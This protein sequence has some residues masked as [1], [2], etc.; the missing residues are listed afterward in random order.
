MELRHGVDLMLR[1]M[2]GWTSNSDCPNI[3]AFSGGSAASGFAGAL[4]Q[5][6]MYT[7][8]WRYHHRRDVVDNRL[9]ITVTLAPWVERFADD[10][11]RAGGHVVADRQ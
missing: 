11:N 10:V 1:A 9:M 8:R 7:S 3:L 6:C 4:A 5:Q 2:S